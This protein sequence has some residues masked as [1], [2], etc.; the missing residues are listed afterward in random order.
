MKGMHSTAENCT[1]VFTRV[2]KLQLTV[3]AKTCPKQHT[4]CAKSLFKLPPHW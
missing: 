2:D 4:S 3:A 1:Q